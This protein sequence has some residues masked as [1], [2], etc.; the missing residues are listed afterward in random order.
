MRRDLRGHQALA[1]I[2]HIWQAKMLCRGHIAEEVRPRGSSDGTSDGGSD[3]V[4]TGRD[5]GH[6][7]PEHVER[8]IVAQA[9]FH[10][11]VRR[12]LIERHM[13][14]TFHHDL[15]ACIPRTLRELA[16]FNELGDL[17]CVTCVVA[18]A[19]THC[20]ANGNGHVV[21]MENFEHFVIVLVER[22]LVSRRLHPGENERTAARNDVRQAA[23]LLEGL[24]HAPVHARMDGH[25][26]DAVL[27][28]RS[29]DVEEIVCGDGNE[30][31]LQIA[32]GIVHRN[33]ADHG[34]RT[35]DKRTAEFLRLAVVGKIHDSFGTQ[36]KRHLDFAPLL[37]LVHEVP[38][39]AQVHVHFRAQ[40]FAHAFGRKRRMV[41]VRRNGNTPGGNALAHELDRTT[42]LL[43]D[44][45]HLGRD[46]ACACSVH[47]RHGDS[48]RW[49]YPLQVPRVEA[50]RCLLS[51][52]PAA[53]RRLRTIAP[54]RRIAQSLRR[55]QAPLQNMSLIICRPLRKGSSFRETNGI[56]ARNAL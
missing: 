27:R 19:R 4:V 53:S 5:V 15:H 23:G 42:F 3:M 28:M 8:R 20:V 56:T 16:D 34:R 41:N 18:G 22:V 45:F 14:R 25:E 38:G 54:E 39:D 36:L 51:A 33:R 31:F 11:H 24:D 43:R 2:V 48:L 7:R 6:E 9:L 21:L 44:R 47:L 35:F 29:N 12:D 30:R 46:D 13:P 26:V 50:I 1:H 37:R 52:C 49:H 10:L 40:S 32:D 55:A 17:R